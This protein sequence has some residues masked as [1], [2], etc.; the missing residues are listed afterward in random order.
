MKKTKKQNSQTIQTNGLN[1]AIFGPPFS[2]GVQLS[3]VDTLYK[4]NRWYLVSNQRQVLSQS[5]VE[6]GLIQTLI[7][8]PVDDALR[9]GINIITDQIEQRD[10]D[11]LLAFMDSHD[12]LNI[13]G[14]ALKWNRLYGGAGILIISDQDYKEKFSFDEITENSNLDF[15]AVDMWELFWD[16]QSTSDY[17]EAI[18]QDFKTV[19]FYRYYGHSVHN[20]RVL[21]MKGKQAPSFIRPRL[22]GWGLSVVETLIRSIN[23]YLKATDLTFEVL[24]E[25]KLD[26]F[27]IKNLVNTLMSPNGE[28]AVHKRVDIANRQKNYQNA[29]TMDSEDDYVQKQLSFSGLSDVMAGIRQQVASDLRMPMTKLFGVSSSGF[30]S[31]EDDIENYNSMIESEI[32]SK[33]K[34]HLL[35]IVKLRCRQ[36]YGFSPDDMRIEFKPLRILSSEQVENVKTS[37]FNR[38][39]QAKQVGEITSEE[40]REAVNKENL[41]GIQLLTDEQSIQA[42]MEEHKL[43]GDSQDDLVNRNEA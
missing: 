29:I 28:V 35:K 22:R 1:E 21:P 33:I 24:D 36:L 32:R 25:F 41:L 37:Q 34:F 42:A 19:E 43:K 26:I 14:Q 20:S 9:G 31:G 17:S 30:N 23:Q 3:Q 11:D 15:K 16:L 10:I 40:F 6:H 39:L 8:V 27:K 13:A 4:N 5:Y 18:V 2:E 12:D 38:L 7:D